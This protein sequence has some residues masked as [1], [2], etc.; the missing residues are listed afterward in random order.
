[1]GQVIL[2]NIAWGASEKP[3]K[4]ITTGMVSIS[5]F[6]G[7]WCEAR[8]SSNANFRASRLEQMEHKD[9]QRRV[10]FQ[11]KRFKGRVRGTTHQADSPAGGG[12]LSW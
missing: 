5:I 2:D 11:E 8:S 9:V 4:Q 7:L 6:S 10:R 1:M 12:A 3:I